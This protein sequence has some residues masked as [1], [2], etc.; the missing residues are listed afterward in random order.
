M[1][2]LDTHTLVWVLEDEPQLGPEARR[3]VIETS[4]ANG[5]GISAIAPWEIALL[6]EN[7]RLRLAREVADW[8]EAALGLPGLR[9]LPIEPRIAVDSARLP[10]TFH[11]DPADRLIV[12][13]ARFWH[14]P[15]VTADA[16][17]LAYGRAGLVEVIDAST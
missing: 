8:I 10:G 14:A 11:P 2:V 1:I 4:N 3:A 9:T 13:T 12:A 15:L 17:I 6:V 16:D 5:V 7:G